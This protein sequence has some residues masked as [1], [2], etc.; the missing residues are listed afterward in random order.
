MLVWHNPLFRDEKGLTYHSPNL[1]R[2]GVRCW[3]QLADEGVILDHLLGIVALTWRARYAA[4]TAE[5]YSILQA[6]SGPPA[7]EVQPAQGKGGWGG[8]KADLA[9]WSGGW[10][11]Q[12][13]LLH[14]APAEKAEAR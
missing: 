4:Q 11:K 12:R 9:G 3:E 5:Y 2:Q 10:G 13:V 14:I 1:I 7:P 6:R 8:R